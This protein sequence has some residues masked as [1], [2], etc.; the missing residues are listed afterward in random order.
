MHFGIIL[1]NNIPGYRSRSLWKM[2]I[3]TL[4]YFIMLLSLLDGK[5]HLF[6]TELSLVF[7]VVIVRLISQKINANPI[8]RISIYIGIF[9]MV[10][11]LG[12]KI[13]NLIYPD[14]YT[15]TTFNGTSMNGKVTSEDIKKLDKIAGIDKDSVL[16]NISQGG[17]EFV[18]VWGPKDANGKIIGVTQLK[19]DGTFVKY[20]QPDD[21]NNYI[22]GTWAYGDRLLSFHNTQAIIN[23]KKDMDNIQSLV[24]YEILSFKDG[25]MK[26][27]N[28]SNLN[29][30]IY[31]RQ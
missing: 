14:E 1:L 10:S 24:N 28:L 7:V 16:H 3:A 31:Y 17:P 11:I 5:I 4:F 6:M 19:E 29:E 27:R 8:L 13:A 15:S 20:M 2:V 18:G 22:S 30:Y 23:G 21:M 25:V 9:I 26:Y 12:N